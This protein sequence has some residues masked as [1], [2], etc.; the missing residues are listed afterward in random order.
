MLF[1]RQESENIPQLH[2]VIICM[3]EVCVKAKE[4]TGCHVLWQCHTVR[5]SEFSDS[6]NSHSEPNVYIMLRVHK[7]IRV[8]T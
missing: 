6:L 3:M 1:E 7:Y 4:K 8:R 5:E 2:F